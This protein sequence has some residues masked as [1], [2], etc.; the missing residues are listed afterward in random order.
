MAAVRAYALI[1]TEAVAVQVEAHVRPGLPGVSMVGLPGVAVREARERVRSGAASTGMPL[2]T[3]RI[4]V[5]LS[6]ADVR[7]EGPGFDLPVALAVLAASGYVSTGALQGVGAMGE[8]ALDGLLR[9]IRG[10]LSVA[11]AARDDGI[12]LLIVPLVGL[13]EVCAVDGVRAVGVRDLREAVMVLRDAGKRERLLER[14]RR[15]LR[16]RKIEAFVDRGPDLADIAGQRHAKRALE[17]AA[18][19]G[20][21]LMMVGPPGAGKTMLA[22]RL[23][24]VLPLLDAT[25]ALEVTRVWSVAGLHRPEDGLATRRPFRAPH[26]SASRSAVIGGGSPPRPGEASL[27]HRGVLFLDEFPEFSRDVIESLRQPL[28]EGLV[29]ISR[30]GGSLTLPAAFTLV[31]AMNPCP[32]G[33][34]MHPER[35]CRCTADMLDR[36][37]GRLSGAVGDRIDLFIDVPPLELS[38][39]DPVDGRDDDSAVVRAR[40]ESARSFRL[41]RESLLSALPC[42]SE[43]GGGTGRSHPERLESRMGVSD[44]ARSLLR[45]ALSRHVVGG[46]GYVR[47]LTVART[48]ADLDAMSAISPDHVAEALSLRD[49][50][51][52]CRSLVAAGLRC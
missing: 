3:Q 29:V 7:K 40:V 37:R 26:H 11:E 28:E 42:S 18:A 49:P 44:G 52:E 2:P 1:G 50:G 22:R 32:C 6:P 48:L 30:K 46:R 5:N 31:G 12:I 19:G 14:G 25:E 36:Y 20:H 4:T 16:T 38:A 35:A 41:E 10:M 21:H 33:N 43:E 24:S 34:L 27:A 47:A 39:F 13:A 23:P 17:V 45:E 8:L 51:C 9:P 15:W